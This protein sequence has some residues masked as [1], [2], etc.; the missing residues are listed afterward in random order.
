MEPCQLSSLSF[1][2]PPTHNYCSDCPHQHRCPS[3]GKRRS[4]SER[5]NF[6]PESSFRVWY[7]L[8]SKIYFHF[9]QQISSALPTA[10]G[11]LKRKFVYS[12]QEDANEGGNKRLPGPDSPTV[13]DEMMWSLVMGMHFGIWFSMAWPCYSWQLY[14]IN[15]RMDL[16]TVP[17]R[18]Y[19]VNRGLSGR[20]AKMASFVN[21]G[22]L[23]LFRQ[24]TIQPPAHSVGQTAGQG[25]GNIRQTLFTNI[26]YEYGKS[27]LDD[28]APANSFME[29]SFCCCC[30]F[31]LAHFAYLFYCVQYQYSSGKEG[32]HGGTVGTWNILRHH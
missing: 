20:P 2:K 9:F 17:S 21:T 16:D 12:L 24:R 10:V 27:F 32:N 13:G 11:H 28:A 26:I 15:P 8:S 6:F 18:H 1:T 19:C 30:V 25:Q 7:L 5:L 29:Q 23:L 14:E 31:S 22:T 3:S 4:E